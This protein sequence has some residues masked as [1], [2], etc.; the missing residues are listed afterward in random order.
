MYLITKLIKTGLAKKQNWE[1]EK[2]V[3]GWLRIISLHGQFDF[4][5]YLEGN[6]ILTLFNESHGCFFF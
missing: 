6:Y 1:G 5:N 2:N 4:N 3:C